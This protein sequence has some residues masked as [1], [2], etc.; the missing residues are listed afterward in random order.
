MEFFLKIITIPDEKVLVQKNYSNYTAIKFDLD[1]F[2]EICK[3]NLEF[4][5]QVISNEN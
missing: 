1:N 2:F 4:Q 3:P 5:I